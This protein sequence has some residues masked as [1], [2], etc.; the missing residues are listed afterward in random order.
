[1]TGNRQVWFAT[2]RITTDLKDNH[3]SLSNYGTVSN[4]Q[5]FTI[6]NRQ[7]RHTNDNI[8]PSLFLTDNI[9]DHHLHNIRETKIVQ[10]IHKATHHRRRSHAPQPPAIKNNKTLGTQ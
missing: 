4:N 5:T 10:L 3:Q 8:T 6:E 2:Q 9:K 7:H 1:V